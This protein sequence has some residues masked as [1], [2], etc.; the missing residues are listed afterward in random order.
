MNRF[1]THRKEVFHQLWFFLSTFFFLLL[2]ICFLYGIR[3]MDNC[4]YDAQKE[5]LWETIQK[6]IAECYAIEG[7][8]PPSLS[9]LEEHYGLVYNHHLF[10]VDYISIGSN[11]YPDVTVIARTQK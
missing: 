3:K 7:T 8:Y 2:F 11:I 9:Y 5:R 6:D 1:Q 4:S 10:Y